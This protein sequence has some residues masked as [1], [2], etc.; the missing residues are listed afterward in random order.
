M[1]QKVKRMVNKTLTDSYH[2]RKCEVCG[3]T[4]TTCG[5]HIKSKGSGGHD[6]IENL[7]A[8]CWEH[9]NFIHTQGL[10]KLTQKF[11]HIKGT[12]RDKGWEFFSDKW[13]RPETCK[14]NRAS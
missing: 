8:L 11:P 7:L 6:V 3:K 13:I 12:L 4:D 14:T 9:H 2:N 10:L 5:H 1:V